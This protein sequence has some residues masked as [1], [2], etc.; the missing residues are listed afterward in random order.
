MRFVLVFAAMLVFE[1]GSASCML[2]SSIR[3]GESR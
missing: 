1:M 3:R 2:V